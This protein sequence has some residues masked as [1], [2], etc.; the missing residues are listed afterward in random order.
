M[1]NASDTPGGLLID[2]KVQVRT[3]DRGRRIDRLPTQRRRGRM[4]HGGSPMEGR[5]YRRLPPPEASPFVPVGAVRGINGCVHELA[6]ACCRCKVEC[7]L[8]A[9]H[10][11]RR[12]HGFRTL[13]SLELAESARDWSPMTDP[14]QLDRFLEAQDGIYEQALAEIRR[15]A[16]RSHWMWFIFPQVAGLGSSAMSQRYAINSL[17]EA[18]AYLE[19]PVL[20]RRL[21]DCVSALQ[22]LPSATAYEVFGDVDASKL[23]SSLTLFIEA[24]GGPLFEAALDRWFGS[25]RDDATLKLLGRSAD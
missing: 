3:G 17:D 24:G 4:A 12:P 10:D 1:Y 8:M 16:K 18:Q 5:H 11:I 7:N 13:I 22:D 9:Q 23:C 25:E 21:R 6:N 2:R 15:G 14:Y 20:G 19:H